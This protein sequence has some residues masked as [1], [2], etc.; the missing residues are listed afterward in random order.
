MFNCYGKFGFGSI[1]VW[2]AG[3]GTSNQGYTLNLDRRDDLLLN[4]V[5][6]DMSFSGYLSTAH[7]SYMYLDVF[8][9]NG[10][11]ERDLI[12][13]ES[14]GS[15]NRVKSF[16]L[17]GR[18]E[19]LG[20]SSNVS[21]GQSEKDLEIYN[22]VHAN[23][24]LS[25]RSEVGADVMIDGSKRGDVRLT[26]H[27][28]D[29]VIGVSSNG[30]GW[31][32]SFNVNARDG[33]DTILF[34]G[35]IDDYFFGYKLNDITGQWTTLKVRGGA[36][37]DVIDS[38]SLSSEDLLRGNDGDDII[39]SGGGDDI[40]IG[41]RGNDELSGGSG[42][43]DLRGGQDNDLLIGGA[44]D[45]VLRG[46]RGEDILIGDNHIKVGAKD[47]T[48][49]VLDV[50]FAAQTADLDFSDYA[51]I[52][53]IKAALAD[54]G[55]TARAR[56]INK[57]ADR[58]T[59][60]EE[61]NVGF[62]AHG[63]GIGASSE[64]ATRPWI[65][66]ET[67]YDPVSGHSELIEFD[68]DKPVSEL[69]IDLSLFFSSREGAD[70]HQDE[71]IEYRLYSEGKL[72]AT[73]IVRADDADR[74]T[75][76]TIVIDGLIT[77]GQAFDVIQLEALPY[78]NQHNNAGFFND[79]SDFLIGGL[80]VTYQSDA[81][82]NDLLRGG[83]DDDILVGGRG[84]DELHGGYGSDIAV[85]QGDLSEYLISQNGGFLIVE[86]TMAGRD[87]IDQT[88]GIEFYQFNDVL[89]TRDQVIDGVNV[90]EAPVAVDDMII[91][92]NEDFALAED[93]ALDTISLN[94][95]NG[96]IL[97]AGLTGANADSDPEGDPIS[98]V[99]V[100]GILIAG[101][102]EIQGA[103]G[104]LVINEAGDATY[105]RDDALT[106]ALNVDDRAVDDFDYTISDG[107]LEDTGLL[108]FAIKGE[109][110][111]PI[112]V[113]ATINAVEDIGQILTLDDF[114]LA[115]RL[116]SEID[117]DNEIIDLKV[118]ITKLPAN[119]AILNGGM[120]M[121][122]NAELSYAD[123]QSG[124]IT[125]LGDQ[126]YNGLDTLSYQLLDP[127][128]GLS[129][130][131]TLTI[132][133]ADVIDNT[134]PTVLISNIQ[135]LPENTDASSNFVVATLILT[136]AEQDISTLDIQLSSDYRLDGANIIYDGPALD[137][138]AGDIPPALDVTVTDDGG[139]Q[140]TASAQIDL[141]NLNDNA[142][143]LNAVQLVTTIDENATDVLVARITLPVADA[144]G[145]AVL[146]SVSADYELR[147]DE[148]FYVGPAL[149][150]EAG[151]TFPELIIT[152][153]DGVNSDS[154]TFN[155]D[156]VNLNDNAPI[157]NA[158]QLVTAIDENATDVLV[159]RITLPVADADGDAVI[160]SVSADY[161]LRGDEIFYVG[162]AL[163]AEAGA[164]FP[165]LIIT[166]SDGVNSDSATFNFD[167]T[168]LNDNA[169]ILNAVQLVTTI[170]EN[171]TDVLVARITLPVADADGD[172]VI[173][174]VSADYELR[175]DEIFY[176]GPA[177]DAEAGAT[178]PELIITASDGVNS[179]S[180]TFNFDLVNLN[181]NAPI[182]NAV[183]LVT[184]IDE[185]ATD[186]LV[187]RI[188]LPVADADGDAV[189]S[190]VS[191]GYA[192]R[193]NEIFYR[194]S[195][196]D[197]EAGDAVP[198]LVI[199]VSDGVN[200]DSVTFN[201]DLV[202]LN[203][204][205]P[206]ITVDEVF[207]I[208]ENEPGAVL[209]NLTIE[210]A[211]GDVLTNIVDDPRFELVNV[212]GD[213]YILKL[214]DTESLDA[215]DANPA[216][217]TVTADDGTLSDNVQIDLAVT[218]SIEDLDGSNGYVVNGFTVGSFSTV[219]A[220]ISAADD[221]NGDG[222]DDFIIGM[223]SNE[224]NS[225]EVYVVF[226][227]TEP[228]SASFNV[229]DIDGTNGFKLFRNDDE[230]PR[231][232]SLGT[233]VSNVGDFNGDGFN[234]IL[235][236][237]PGVST[238]DPFAPPSDVGEAYLI[239]GTD[240]PFNASFNLNNLNKAD[241]ITFAGIQSRANF[242]EPVRGAG[243]INGDGFNDIIIG[244][245]SAGGNNQGQSYVVFGTDQ[246]F[247]SS[248]EVSSLNGTNGFV[249]N[250]I[251]GRDAT[252]RAI[253]SAG[254]FNGDGF[255]DL[256]IGA[257]FGD[258]NGRNTGET[259]LVFGSDQPFNATFELSDLD[260]TN[261][262]QLNGIDRDDRAGN[263]VSRAGD[264]NGDGFDDIF[265]AARD[266]DPNGLSSGEV[267]LVFGTDQP[268]GA[269]FELSDLDGTNGIQFNGISRSDVIGVVS[270]AGDVNGDGFDDV[271][272][273]SQNA[274]GRNGQAYVIFGTDQLSSATFEL[275]SLDGK[276]GFKIDAIN[277]RDGLG[278]AVSDAGDVNGD[279]FDDLL[280]NAKSS[281]LDNPSETYV[282]FG[283]EKFSST[284][285][286]NGTENNDTLDG[287]ALSNIL[288]GGLGDDV[289]NTNGGTDTA[290][291]GAGDDTINIIDDTFFRIDG[292][293]GFDTLGVDSDMVLDFGDLDQNAIQNIEAIDLSLNLGDL[294]I[295][296]L[297]V[298]NITDSGN[299]LR[300]DGDADN[301]VTLEGNWTNTG[302]VDQD[303]QTYDVYNI[304]NIVVQID[305]DVNTVIV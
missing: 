224:R 101:M 289:L 247:N 216:N 182:L 82:G 203:D 214:L 202:N 243:D 151:A 298:I 303:G 81:E 299:V 177:L 5:E 234:D 19:D 79:S 93:S 242:G 63:G 215:D 236:G 21:D 38:S 164:T 106:Q 198:P 270:S 134:A 252:G 98:I 155:F 55:V 199:T 90:N 296:D 65:D 89:Y 292:G 183:Q 138:E 245:R 96:S 31:R 132:D 116:A 108:S 13:M 220:S 255:D 157:L 87:G 100:N 268:L 131:A 189:I 272:I 194:G 276:N 4:N 165:E 261:G 286:L 300:V 305:M 282:I 137:F 119:G 72:I 23:V 127:E 8:N 260:G 179:D 279:G 170:D 168:N 20:N 197:A 117:V 112:A 237:A 118:V 54:A 88:R 44:G 59:N 251:D 227:T 66:T 76:Q 174:S 135:D 41:N 77:N 201:F 162:P 200:T 114:G 91:Q 92:T 238:G 212:S 186:V 185:N 160:V 85:Y 206:T 218:I 97:T 211:D 159:A 173:A 293:N 229:A 266:A 122:L 209:A 22:Y 172:A 226:G 239:F 71:V 27:D 219:L 78:N 254:D 161:E 152:A 144:D 67:G 46:H 210:D 57:G 15:W 9:S 273:G 142:P 280:V 49:G 208:E 163:D 196:L 107:S 195:E 154:A 133:I 139:L 277:V 213:Q 232:S 42:N 39:R 143:I 263:E 124:A 258:A 191:A 153:S 47:P 304:N 294:I 120:P 287:D 180:A 149:D 175:G 102:T 99:S 36:G 217:I 29:L 2:I 121:G 110:D 33:D 221:F 50:D 274:G 25:G 83:S 115:G 257:F 109:N 52:N 223:S 60:L 288:V 187:A 95:L 207:S 16:E 104:K 136:D 285:I 62:S 301:N 158:V 259:Y 24:K 264:F 37:D 233:S 295:S 17:R 275:S 248:F 178:F 68:F 235:I 140:A 111:A 146:I 123:I 94:V 156:L 145:D 45:D 40:L 188:T 148:V 253:D 11:Y 80:R 26:H 30:S 265:I 246:P 35:A 171:A 166:A 51:N 291:G 14:Y 241:G 129:N 284:P 228:L 249:L 281:L 244:A 12:R 190:S 58:L 126:D 18:A 256:I 262:V 297:E 290:K 184:T 103:Y 269:S 125:Y 113:N 193:G 1:S 34:R 167:L 10:A 3:S 48:T 69:E 169:P 64:A 240:Q 74:Q 75:T 192:F 205:A 105:V 53:A 150:A 70:Y 61:D 147:G 141:T 130:E 302:T 222:I 56:N 271:I 28:D 278:I 283:G 84:D 204:N 43:D 128:G 176:V 225:S 7:R 6:F 250:G 267:Y 230:Q 181:D 32:N 231:G 86:D 73:E